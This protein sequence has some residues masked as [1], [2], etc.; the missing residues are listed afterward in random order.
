MERPSK[1]QTM[2]AVLCI[3]VLALAVVVIVLLQGETVFEY[4]RG[5]LYRNGRFR[6]VLPPGRHRHFRPWE[7]VT[8]VDVREDIVTI[9]GQ[10][11]LSADNVSLKTSIALR[12]RVEDPALAVNRMANYRDALYLAAQI[13]V[14]NIVGSTEIEELLVKRTDV[15]KRLLEDCRPAA[16]EMGIELLA[17]DIKDVIFPGELKSVFAQVVNARKEGQAALERA[18][19]ET[20]ALRNLANAARLLEENPNLRHLRLFQI[21]EKNP[22][23]TVVYVPPEEIPTLT[24]IHKPENPGTDSPFSG[25]IDGRAGGDPLRRFLSVCIRPGEAPCN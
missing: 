22:G 2:D 6:K 11:V 8:K 4:Q 9:P 21:L 12:Y 16:R 14:R 1:G 23:N 18:R 20:A 24:K 7:T 10:E 13:A 5:L 19:G 17:A 3:S 25:I 15:G